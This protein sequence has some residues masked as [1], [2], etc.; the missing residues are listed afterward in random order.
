MPVDPLEQRKK[1]TFAQAE[2]VEPLPSQLKPKE[3][4]KALR[5]RLWLVVYKYLEADSYR[6]AGAGKP[7]FMDSWHEIFRSMHV[8]RDAGMID[9]FKNDFHALTAKTK[10]VFADGDYIEIFGWLQ[11]VFRHTKRPPS[12]EKL[13]DDVLEQER[14]AYRVVGRDTICPVGS[15]PERETIERAFVDLA[16]TE[17]HGARQHLRNAAQKL[18]AGEI[19]DSIRESI[20]A[21]EFDG[22]RNRA[23][24]GFFK[25]SCDT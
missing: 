21:V 11:Y 9:E 6:S 8:D 19:A 20:H 23:T 10:A 22:A 17:F 12:F 5:A 3:I 4:S 16:A 1:L 15:E 2:G 25:G 24:K 13:V 7:I 14:A 18:T